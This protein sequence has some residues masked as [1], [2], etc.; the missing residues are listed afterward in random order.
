VNSAPVIWLSK[1]QATIKTSVFGSE[2]V[3]MKHGVETLRGLRDK[4]RMMGIPISGP[5]YVYGDNMSVINN[6]QRPE[7]TLKKKSKQICYHTIRES[8]AMGECLTVHIASQENLAD[9]AT[10]IIPGGQKR[11]YLVRQ[12]LYDIYNDA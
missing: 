4:L 9:I 12:I 11:T 1:K 10:K 8:V 3:A 2:F 6:T 5:S 7:S